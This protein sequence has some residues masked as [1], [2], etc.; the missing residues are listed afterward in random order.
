M[1]HTADPSAQCT[2]QREGGQGWT[3][4]SL[5]FIHSCNVNAGLL[6]LG[7]EEQRLSVLKPSLKT[8]DHKISIVNP[9]PKC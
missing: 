7:M 8:M 4:G 6:Q 9:A 3:G 5:P 1:T 2:E